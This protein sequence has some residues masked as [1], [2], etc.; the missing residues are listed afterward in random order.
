MKSEGYVCFKIG[1][2]FIVLLGGGLGLSR[3]GFGR[4]EWIEFLMW[5]I[6]FGI[7]VEVGRS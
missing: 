6:D 5:K 4:W 3:I 7:L 1:E 2:G